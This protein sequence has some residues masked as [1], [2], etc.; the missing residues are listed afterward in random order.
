METRYLIVNADD[1]G[2]SAGI[3]RGIIEAHECGIVTSAS[4]MVCWPGAKEAAAYSHRHAEFSVGLH[5]DLGEWTYTDG[6]WL[7]I[8][9]RVALEN[10]ENLAAEVTRQL[11]IFRAL[12][13]RDPTHLDSHQHVH[14]NEPL[15]AVMAEIGNRLGVPVRHLSSHIQYCGNFYGQTA[16]GTRITESLTVRALIGIVSSLSAPITELACHPGYAK[17]LETSYRLERLKELRVLRSPTVRA[18]LARFGIKLC[19]FEDVSRMMRT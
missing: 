10:A 5:L 19:S 14:R 8:Y 11:E 12:I 18:S 6:C 13:G 15:R 2:Q 7:P 9:E 17:D 1:F 3:N 16:E 4:L